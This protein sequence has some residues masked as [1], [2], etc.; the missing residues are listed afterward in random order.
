MSIRA[1]VVHEAEADFDTATQLADRVMIEAID[2]LDEDLIVYQRE[3]T[4]VV[5]VERRLTWTGYPT[6]PVRWA[7]R[8]TATSTVNREKR[9]RVRLG[10]RSCT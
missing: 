9:T 3:W 8:H 1:A 4:G 10:G 7:S 6:S 2:W 5:P